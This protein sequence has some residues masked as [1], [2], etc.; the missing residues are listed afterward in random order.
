MMCHKWNSYSSRMMKWNV[1]HVFCTGDVALKCLLVCGSCF[2]ARDYEIQRERI[3]L[4]RCIGEGQFGDVHQGTYTSP[5][6]LSG[7]PPM[8]APPPAWPAPVGPR[9]ALLPQGVSRCPLQG[10]SYTSVHLLCSETQTGKVSSWELVCLLFVLIFHSACVIS[11]HSI[12]LCLHAAPK[13][14]A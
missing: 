10:L 1:S 6:S 12:A 9:E 14:Q 5:V 13:S 8:P 11:N 3:E 2:A 7:G 4:G